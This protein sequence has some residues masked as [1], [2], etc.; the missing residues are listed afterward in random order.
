MDHKHRKNAGKKYDP[1]EER[2]DELTQGTETTHE[3]V[4]DGYME[5]TIDGKI[6][7]LDEQGELKSHDGKEIPR[8]GHPR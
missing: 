5:G 7:S 8:K 6:D 3:Q 2:Q 1:A 4:E